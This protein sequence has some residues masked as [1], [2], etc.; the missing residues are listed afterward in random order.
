MKR[1]NAGIHSFSTFSNKSRF[2]LRALVMMRITKAIITDSAATILM[3]VKVLRNGTERSYASLAFSP[4]G[5]QLA[6]VGGSPD[7][8]LTIWNWQEERVLLH[9]KAFG[10]DVF[11]VR[12][13]PSMQLKRSFW[14]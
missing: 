6:S 11:K 1:S 13:G 4:D 3:A 8:M 5:E 9:T 12:C 10:Q 7:F 2:L 14:C